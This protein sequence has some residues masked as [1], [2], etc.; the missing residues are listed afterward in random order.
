MCHP[1]VPEGAVAPDVERREL[2]I[3]TASGDAI[4]AL[5]VYPDAPPRG[6]I[7]VVADIYGRSPF[8]EELTARLA[9]A[10]FVAV[11]PDLFFRLGALAER[12]FEVAAARR[13]KLD[14]AT[15]LR[16]LT[17]VA[18]HVRARTGTHRV[19]TIGFCMGGTLVLQLTAKLRDLAT[20]C[21]YLFPG[22]GSNRPST[23]PRPLEMAD[24]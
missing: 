7:V 5:L 13:A 18:D 10:G 3:A 24:Q 1:E 16:D 2:A 21:Y 11:L 20:V 19:G 23:V 4:P 14:D 9:T 8:Y 6:G 17:A 22:P 15:A 12:T